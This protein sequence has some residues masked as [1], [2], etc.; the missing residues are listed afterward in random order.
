M[1]W[2]QRQTILW[3]TYV[4]RQEQGWPKNRRETRDE[5]LQR[6]QRTA[7]KFPRTFITQ[8]IGDM[9]RRCQRLF[10]AKGG[11]FEEGGRSP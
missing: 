7:F 5:Y 4:P 9:A 1:V 6:L 2:L 10:E 3:D 8:S 11:L